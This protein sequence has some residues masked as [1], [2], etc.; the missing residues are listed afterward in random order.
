[1]MFDKKICYLLN[2]VKNV[3]SKKPK[4]WPKRLSSREREEGDVTR[5]KKER[6]KNRKTTQP[7]FCFVFSTLSWELQK[8]NP[9]GRKFFIFILTT[10]IETALY[11]YIL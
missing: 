2:D 1:M 5:E 8:N 3:G 9:A 4:S 11:E 6:Q 10:V 7:D